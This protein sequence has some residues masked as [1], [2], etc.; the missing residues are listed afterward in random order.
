MASTRR[1]WLGRSALALLLMMS[2]IAATLAGCG[3]RQGTAD[4]ERQDANRTEQE[5]GGRQTALEED[6]AQL[7]QETGRAIVKFEQIDG[8]TYADAEK[9][10]GLIGFH[11][12]YSEDGK[13][14][15]IGDH[16][17]V[18]SIT[19][20][21]REVTKEERTLTMTSPARLRDGRMLV[22]AGELKKLFEDEAV[23]TVD[24]EQA[25]IFPK[26]PAEDP[27]A[28]EKDFADDPANPASGREA[29]EA[30]LA[31]EGG[32]GGGESGS[33][34][35]AVSDEAV[36]VIK[37]AS[38]LIREAKR[39]L[40]VKY[41]FG[42]AHYSKSKR[43][44]CSSYVQYLFAKYGVDMPRTARAQ[45]RLGVKVPRDKLRQ[46]DLLYFYVPGRFK[47]D[48]KVGH[49]GI[50]IGNKKMIHSSP[51]PQDGV[52]ITDI[53]KPYWKETFLFAKRV[54]QSD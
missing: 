10:A 50:Y 32:E 39:Y 43:F 42:A 5:D 3:E 47:S 46:G 7:L 26:P 27:A 19:D 53:N 20:Q 23:F 18:M 22:P 25:A 40:G 30:W 51:L 38:D 41:K 11:T 37:N 44:D 6:N 21:S 1:K 16:D 48:T 45:A 29:E 33:E 52:Q 34:G 31:G 36:P 24:A 8:L 4:R 9:M 13:S 17:V 28:A 14:L 49:V 35:P 15:L 2:L 12:E 54:S